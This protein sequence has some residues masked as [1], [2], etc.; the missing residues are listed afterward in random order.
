MLVIIIGGLVYWHHHSNSNKGIVSPPQASTKS[1]TS[2]NNY[3]AA[4]AADNNANND[5][6]GSSSPSSTL[7][8]YQPPPDT[9]SFS[10]SITRA[11][12][13][14]TD[15]QVATLINGATSGS[16][17]LN[18]YQAGQ[19][20]ISQSEDVVLQVNSY[21]C[22]VFNVPL[23]QFPNHGQWN[24]SVTVTSNSKTVSS[25]WAKNPVSLN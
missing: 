22:P 4:P 5:R 12:T 23:S 20:T 11:N 7:E 21:V 18:V 9:G 17:T 24:V 13:D 2:K 15:L 19:T 6:K 3:S 8:N 10:V 14:S 16:C 25:N 1:P